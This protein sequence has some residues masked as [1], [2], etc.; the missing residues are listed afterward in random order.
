M[1][2]TIG[3]GWVDNGNYSNINWDHRFYW[4]RYVGNVAYFWVR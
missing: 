3:E 2:T 4:V 1:E